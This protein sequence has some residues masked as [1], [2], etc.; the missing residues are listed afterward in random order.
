MSA[1]WNGESR[2]CVDSRRFFVTTDLKIP[3][4]RFL[5]NIANRQRQISAHAQNFTFIFNVKFRACA[6]IDVEIFLQDSST[7]NQND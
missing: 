3:V 6:K 5:K 7:T 2:A 4:L 1:F